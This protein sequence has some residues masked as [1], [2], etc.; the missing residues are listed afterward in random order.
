[1]RA[2]E[3]EQMVRRGGHD[4]PEEDVVRRWDRSRYHFWNQYRQLADRWKLYFNGRDGLVP[5][6]L[7]TGSQLN[8]Y[9]SGLWETFQG[10][11]PE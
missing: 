6:A 1:M 3:F 11:M 4:V 9:E 10:D 2:E 8:V 5:V 7:G